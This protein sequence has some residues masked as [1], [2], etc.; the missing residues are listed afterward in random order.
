[1][2][3]SGNAWYGSACATFAVRAFVPGM[4]SKRGS[5]STMVEASCLQDARI[6]FDLGGAVRDLGFQRLRAHHR[7][8]EVGAI[9][10]EG[11]IGLVGLEALD[12][13]ERGV[14]QLDRGT[15]RRCPA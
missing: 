7:L 9:D 10:G 3:F 1:M 4:I 2:I 13:G 11:Q 5:K 15:S 12:V 8:L 6:A 14:L